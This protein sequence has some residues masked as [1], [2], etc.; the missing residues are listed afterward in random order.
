MFSTGKATTEEL[1]CSA[2]DEGLDA[3]KDQ[4][5]FE[6]ETVIHAPEGISAKDD[7]ETRTR[8]GRAWVRE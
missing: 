6:H 8:V 1:R 2:V 5:S 3:P 7:T 4:I